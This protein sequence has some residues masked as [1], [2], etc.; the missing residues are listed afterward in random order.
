VLHGSKN[1]PQLTPALCYLS[2]T[3]FRQC[4]RSCFCTE[5]FVISIYPPTAQ[6]EKTRRYCRSAATSSAGAARREEK[7]RAVCPLGE[8]VPVEHWCSPSCSGTYPSA[9]A[10][11][12]NAEND[13]CTQFDVIFHFM[14]HFCPDSL[15]R[16][17]RLRTWMRPSISPIKLRSMG[18]E[19]QFTENQFGRK[20]LS[21]GSF[22]TRL[23]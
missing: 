11:E 18:V 12:A 21:L 9:C 14:V 15:F 1:L 10:T 6:C 7:W 22:S 8:T 2:K 17:K 23:V 4:M 5:P 16:L 3:Y 13:I 20:L 19:A